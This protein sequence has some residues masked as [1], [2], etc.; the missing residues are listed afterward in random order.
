[1]T[2]SFDFKWGMPRGRGGKKKEC[3][4]YDSFTYDG[5]DYALYDC[6]YI[7][8]DGDPLPHVGKIIKIW[9]CLDKTKKVKILWFFFPFEIE[10]FLKDVEMYMNEL[11]LACGEGIGQANV[12]VL[13]AIAG[14]CNVV[15]I[16]KDNRNRQPSDE[17]IR[18]ADFIFRRTFDVEQQKVMD[19]TNDSIDKIAGLDVKLLLNRVDIK[20][21]GMPRVDSGQ[22]AVSENAIGTDPQNN[23]S[24]ESDGTNR[25]C[26]DTSADSV[27]EKDISLTN[28]K[29]SVGEK[30]APSACMKSSVDTSADGVAEKDI[31]LTNGK[32]SV[33]E[34][35]AP[36]ACMKSSVDTSAYGVAEKDI[37]LTNG[38]SS[39][40]EKPAPSAYMK[41]VDT[42]KTNHAQENVL[43]LKALSKSKVG[44]DNSEGRVG[45]SIVRDDEIEENFNGYSSVGEKPAP[46]ACMKS[47]DT[48][49]TNRAQENVLDLKALSKSKVGSDNSEGRVGKRIFRDDEI[50][51][52]VNGY[53]NELDDKPAKKPKL[54]SVRNKNSMQQLRCNSDT[55]K[56][57][58]VARTASP[59]DDK[60]E[61]G[62]SKKLIHDNGAT[63]LST[64]SEDH[65]SD[66][67]ELEISRRT[68]VDRSKWTKC[69]SWEDSLRTAHDQGTLVFIQNLD[70]SYSAA[71]VEETIWLAFE[72]KCTAKMVQGTAFSSP[73]FGQ[74]FVIFEKKE[75]AEKVVRELDESCL[76]LPN[77]RPLVGKMGTPFFPEKKKKFCGHLVI[78]KVQLRLQREK[79]DA[80]STSHVSQ[81][82]T[83]EHDMAME[84]CMRQEQFDICWKKL[85]KKQE[86][87][88]SNLKAK[89]KAS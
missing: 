11:F 12:N 83:I 41:S 17:E 77:G 88:L 62:L 58:A 69:L 46:S 33:G 13:E 9:E 86:E 25:L 82:N 56:K 32:S 35:P 27:A 89:L 44:S 24:K 68:K 28:G 76:L 30:P 36:S 37:S 65:K 40:G 81:S 67:Q 43:D 47:V 71:E 8:T 10:N 39:V 16:S 14:K 1:M 75:V 26:I 80:V 53:S 74:A 54:S 87:E 20:S 23:L 31:S 45:K 61:K 19:I 2:E 15:C 6:V 79:K 70:P 64:L 34:K 49:K 55:N 72:K 38:K 18:N 50:E 52:K 73:Y 29:S 59:A 42:E 51:E 21:P 84:W 78:D 66:R 60:T 3:R 85:Y 5:V 48:E 57:E 4:F 63:K 22:K 7:R